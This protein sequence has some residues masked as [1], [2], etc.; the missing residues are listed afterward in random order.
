M[1]LAL[2]ER[3]IFPDLLVGTSW[4]RSTR[5]VAGHPVLTAPTLCD[6]WR[7]IRRTDIYRGSRWTLG[8]PRSA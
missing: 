3:G 8:V 5:A 2:A 4:V 7:S 1:V 6:V